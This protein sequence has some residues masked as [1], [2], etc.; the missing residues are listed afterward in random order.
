MSKINWSPF[1]EMSLYAMANSNKFINIYEG[2]VR[3]TKTV[4]SIIAWI[5]FLKES[6]HSEFLMS[7]KT[8]DTLY[9]NV[10]GGT[11][12]IENLLGPKRVTYRKSSEGGAKLLIRFGKEVKTV[13]C[14]G[15]NDKSSEGNIRG[16]TIGGWYADEATLHPENFIQTAINRMSLAGARAFWTTNP[17]SPYHFIKTEYIDKAEEKGY[18]V[19]HFTL[20]DNLS[21][22]EEYKTNVKR[23]YSGL[24]Y[25]RMIEGL[26]VMAEGVIYEAFN[27][28]TMTVTD[29]DLPKMRRY[30]VGVDYGTSNATV[31]LLAGLGEDNRLYILDEYVHSGRT[32]RQKSPTE[33]SKDFREFLDKHKDKRVEHIF[34]D[35]SANSFS[36]QLWRDGVKGVAQAD[37]SVKEGIEFITNLMT[38]DLIRVHKRCENLLKELSSY[39][40]DPKAQLRGEDK[41]LKKDDHSVDAFRYIGYSMRRMWT[42]LLS[43]VA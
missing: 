32:S 40:W 20:D 19:F 10:I 6:P 25:K 12:G 24:W 39:S 37:N 27:S 34:I 15:A 30:W 29:K 43:K 16:M 8:A 13:Y 3:S 36:V 26:W 14:I 5:D 9:R 18:N 42:S 22:T 28:D 21:L 23:A 41:P 31:F 38:N 4:S 2:S 35:P 1:S 17:D 33:Y 11:T 7:G